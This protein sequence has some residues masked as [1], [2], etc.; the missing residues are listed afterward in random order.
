MGLLSKQAAF[1][2]L[3]AA[4][5]TDRLGHI[6]IGHGCVLDVQTMFKGLISRPMS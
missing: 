6:V 3:R 1:P 5:M 4:T 2:L